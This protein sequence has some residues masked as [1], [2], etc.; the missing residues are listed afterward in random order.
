M[1]AAALLGPVAMLASQM[2]NAEQPPAILQITIERILPGGEPAYGE[3]EER[4]AKACAR[5][6]CPNPYL[7]LESVDA[8]K[9]VWW[10]VEH[11][12]EAAVERLGRAYAANRPL[13][14]ALND[15]AAQK[16]GITEAPIEHIARYQ[17]ERSVAEPWR[18]GSEPFA[19]IA[20]GAGRGAVF[21]SAQL[22]TFTVVSAPSLE[23][24]RAAAADLRSNARVLRVRASWSRP[25]AVWVAAN[26]VLWKSR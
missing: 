6:G 11:A 9:E 16:K 26:P 1:I 23:R 2:S 8:P 15:L 4:M 5:L 19:V 22:A 18:V 17:S 25:A 20:I 21:E 12:E 3:L 7:A 14:D 24:A 13:L 10:F